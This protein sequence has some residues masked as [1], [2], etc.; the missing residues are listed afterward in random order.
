VRT[1]DWKLVTYPDTQEKYELYNLKEDAHEMNNLIDDPACRG[2][3]VQLQKEID[4]LARE[5]DYKENYGVL[6][7]TKK[8]GLM[9]KYDFEEC[10]GR[11]VK[12]LSGHSNHGKILNASIVTSEKGAALR[13]S[14]Q[15]AV[16]IEQSESLD[17]SD[18]PLSVSVWF[19]AESDGTVLSQGQPIKGAWS[20]FIEDGIPCFGVRDSHRIAVADGI[21][22]CLGKWTHL[23]A[24]VNYDKLEIFVDGKKAASVPRGRYLKFF[25][26]KT[27]VIGK[28]QGEQTLGM[29]PAGGF[30]GLISDVEFY[31]R[32]GWRG[33]LNSK[34]KP[35][36][37]S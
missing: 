33:R 36:R 20:L 24:T 26:D 3:A 6:D 30:Q 11:V 23:A 5:T 18:C 15:S 37:S 4:R 1:D 19:K 13:C 2:K 14:S 22:C 8:Q 7:K 29:I 16:I 28:E 35:K 25:G 34:Y 9:L 31:R 17:T 10:D 32:S 27:L 21:E 12:D